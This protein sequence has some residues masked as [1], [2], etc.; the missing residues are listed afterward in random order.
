MNEFLHKQKLLRLAT[1]GPDG[2]PHVVPVWYMYSG[3]RFYVGTHTRT[4]KAKNVMLNG[5]AAVCVDAGVHAPGITGFSAQGRARLILEDGKVKE[6]AGR[7]L[8]RYFESLQDE[9]AQELLADTDCIIEITP[10]RTSSW[11]Y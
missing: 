2:M 7:I 4:G 8:E 1:V 11:Q 6:I 3:R 9:S 5:T 10:L